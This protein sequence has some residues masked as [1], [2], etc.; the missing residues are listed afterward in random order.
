V[1]GETPGI[2]QW[3]GLFVMCIGAFVVAAL[4]SLW[5]DASRSIDIEIAGEPIV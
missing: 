3:N 2:G 1:L 4:S 5:M